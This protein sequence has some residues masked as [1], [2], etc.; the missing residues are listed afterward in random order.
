M[1]IIFVGVASSFLVLP[2]NR[3]V[4]SDG[5]IVKLNTATKVHEELVA[6]LRLMKDWRMLA[7]F[8]MFFASNYFYAYQGSVNA[9]VFDGPTRAL[10]ATLEA[11]GAIVGAL[12]IGYFVLDVKWLHRRHRGYLGLAV[13]TI[14]TIVT[15]A[16]GL[17]WQVTF[18]RDYQSVHNGALI[19]YKDSNYKG[20]GAL[21]FFCMS[22]YWVLIRP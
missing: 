8:P 20:K 11:A 6:M 12:M 15:W 14:L 10:N 5:T 13:V 17:S 4:R 21:Y 9:T 1:V 2:P 7:L 19:N 22:S 16:V 3:V 18:T